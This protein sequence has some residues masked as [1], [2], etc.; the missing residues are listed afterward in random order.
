MNLCNFQMLRRIPIQTTI[1]S[2]N[3]H[4]Q[5]RPPQS[6]FFKKPSQ[7]L[8]SINSPANREARY[9]RMD[10]FLKDEEQILCYEVKHSYLYGVLTQIGHVA[11][12]VATPL[13]IYLRPEYIDVAR[14]QLMALQ[15]F[16]LGFLVSVFVVQFSLYLFFYGKLVPRIYFN[17]R[18]NTFSVITY[19]FLVPFKTART[20][21][22]VE[23]VKCI[24]SH[25]LW[26]SQS[27]GKYMTVSGSSFR[28]PYFKKMF[29]Q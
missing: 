5:K 21:V 25:V 9:R 15:P 1:C 3:F 12:L 24:L 11:S 22:P 7:S 13:V 19:R 8:W 16:E 4:S 29:F 6:N 20:E 23:D 14:N 2:Y 27:S 28:K 17:E 26:K 18:K 10:G